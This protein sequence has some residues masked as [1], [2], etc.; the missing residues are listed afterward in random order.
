LTPQAT[1]AYSAGGLVVERKE[2]S[3]KVAFRISVRLDASA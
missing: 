3:M 1:G 2:M